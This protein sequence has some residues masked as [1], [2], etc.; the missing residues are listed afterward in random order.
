VASSG[1][2]IFLVFFTV[3]G[4]M[5]GAVVVMLVAWVIGAAVGGRRHQVEEREG[6]A[7][8]HAE[9]D[10]AIAVQAERGRIARGLQGSVLRH[11]T[12][13]VTRAEADGWRP[14]DDPEVARAALTA[15]CAEGRAALTAMRELLGMLR[16]EAGAEPAPRA[17]QPTLTG[18]AALTRRHSEPTRPVALTT[19][20]V[21]RAVP[22]EVEISAF[23][24]VERVLEH[25]MI[26][27]PD[28]SSAAPPDPDP[29]AEPIRV[30]VSYG[31]NDLQVSVA[32]LPAESV[33]R[34]P[35]ARALADLGERVDAVGGRLVVRRRDDRYDVHAWFPASGVG[36]SLRA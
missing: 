12:V 10:A 11:T 7:L 4:A 6:Y 27:T 19:E 9:A 14:G 32:E 13:L 22:V 5:V 29:P 20:G 36:T 24:V 16:E 21:A 33:P 8:G 1:E 2:R 35:A 26:V 23:R 15:V 25:A 28:G 31:E 34:G 3:V 30:L 17:P 18:L